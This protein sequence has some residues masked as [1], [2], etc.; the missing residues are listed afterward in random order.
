[1]ETGRH[2]AHVSTCILRARS[3]RLLCMLCAILIPLLMVDSRAGMGQ[4]PRSPAVNG[5]ERDAPKEVRVEPTAGDPAIAARIQRILVSTTWFQGAR[6]AVRDGVVFLDGTTD[7]LEHRRWA[8]QLAENTEGTVAVVNNIEVEADAQSTF[9]LAREE[10]ARIARQVLQ[11]WPWVLLAIVVIL[12]SWLLS[13]LVRRLSTRIL[14]RRIASPLLLKVV[15]QLI[16]IPV[17]LLGIYFVLRVAGLTRLAVTLLGGTGLAGIV[18]G[19]AFRD[20]AENFLASILL[21]V[22][23]PFRTGDLIE[24]DGNKGIVQNLNMRTTALLTLDGNYVQVPN[25]VVFKS[26][27]T[28]YSS[29]ASRRADFAVGIGYGSSTVK[30]QSL[31]SEV[32]KQHPAVLETP[33]PLVLVEEL[34]AATVNLRAYYWFASATYAPEKISSSLMRLTKN[35]LL[36]AGIELPDPAREVVFPNG[37]PL[38]DFDPAKATAVG[39]PKPPADDTAA[40]SCGEGDLRSELPG[41]AEESKVSVPEGERNLLKS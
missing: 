12:L 34:G 26:T 4:A 38:V 19:L 14:S 13:H 32:L 27:I 3:A 33:E 1:M 37:I 31:I 20:I 39:G 21:S 35:A 15:V 18:A 30:A 11:A 9:A 24:V 22:R 2:D 16:S 36:A 28:N 8:G 17:F 5:Q 10:F 6:V 25:A 41:L 7:S 23:N 40:A 29:A